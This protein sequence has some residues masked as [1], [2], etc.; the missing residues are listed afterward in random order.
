MGFSRLHFIFGLSE[1]EISVVAQPS[2]SSP[3][4]MIIFFV[5]ARVTF[6]G[7][8]LEFSISLESELVLLTAT[9]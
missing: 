2:D 4:V 6:Y 5:E 7:G 1:V 8:K 3:Q 9:A